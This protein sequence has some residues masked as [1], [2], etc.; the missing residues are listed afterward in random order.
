MFVYNQGK[1]FTK[2]IH[3][4]VR[5]HPH[6]LPAAKSRAQLSMTLY[7]VFLQMATHPLIDIGTQLVSLRLERVFNDQ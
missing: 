6:Y 3:A 5:H 4:N 2:A 7:I 1:L